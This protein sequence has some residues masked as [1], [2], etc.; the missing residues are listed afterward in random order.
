VRANSVASA[1]QA[2]GIDLK[3][4]NE[5]I[6]R[7]D[8]KKVRERRRIYNIFY[9]EVMVF[10]DPDCGIAFTIVLMILAHYK[11]INDNKSFK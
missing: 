11:V 2:T 7:I 10:A 8:A 3:A 6:S 9:Q 4:L 1:S 5:R